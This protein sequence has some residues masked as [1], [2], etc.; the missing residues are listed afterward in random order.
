MKK[1]AAPV[2]SFLHRDADEVASFLS[3]R[4]APIKI[5]PLARTGIV[6]MSGQYGRLQGVDFSRT[7][8]QAGFRLLP[9][10]KDPSFFF[11]FPKQG[12][13]TGVSGST[14]SIASPDE[15]AIQVDGEECDYLEP[16]SGYLHISVT[17]NKAVMMQR[18]ALI[19][20]RPVP[21]KI[22]FAP[23]VS[24]KSKS[25]VALEQLVTYVVEGN[26]GQNVVETPFAAARM[27][28]LI[29]D[30]ILETW[31]NNFSAE[32]RNPPPAIHPKHVKIAKEYIDA[33]PLNAVGVEELARLSGVSVRALQ[34][35]FRDFLGVSISQY[36]RRRR[37]EGA[38][39][40]ILSGV[41][42]SIKDVASIWGFSNVHRFGVDFKSAFG[43]TPQ[44]LKRRI[45]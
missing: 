24:I 2:L 39:N 32:L 30:M 33:N 26:F 22:I 34:Y 13:L 42:T 5:E 41:H 25:I 18:L 27:S 9:Q 29:A 38:R 17:I 45:L 7:G 23:T 8:F 35:G 36:E 14:T 21:G 3:E 31:P 20:D 4:F 28:Q 40:A 15:Y 12:I 10:K 43:I 44:D 19:L 1:E 11:I 37:L 6:S 16:Q